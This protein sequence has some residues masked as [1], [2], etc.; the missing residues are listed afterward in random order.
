MLEALTRV[1]LLQVLL[2]LVENEHFEV[3]FAP[4]VDIKILVLLPLLVLAREGVQELLVGVLQA[5]VVRLK[6]DVGLHGFLQLGL[7][8]LLLLLD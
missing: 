7:Q 5:A 3:E 1:H 8:Q 2:D 6:P 4:S